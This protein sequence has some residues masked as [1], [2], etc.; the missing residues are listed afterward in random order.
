[1][2]GHESNP[3]MFIQTYDAEDPDVH[4]VLQIVLAQLFRNYARLT[5]G[6]NAEV[7]SGRCRQPSF[8]RKR[9]DAAEDSFI[10][11]FELDEHE[12]AVHR[13]ILKIALVRQSEIRVELEASLAKSAEYSYFLVACE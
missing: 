12:L 4:A 10:G 7:F 11:I 8:G 5:H 9:R 6:A 3:R 2:G 1:M 13:D